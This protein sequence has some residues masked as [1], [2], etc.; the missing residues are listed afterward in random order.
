MCVCVRTCVCACMCVC[1][2]VCICVFVCVH[3]CV[4]VRVHVCVCM[5]VRV[6]VCAC[7]YVHETYNNTLPS[8]ESEA[9]LNFTFNGFKGQVITRSKFS[10]RKKSNPV[11]IND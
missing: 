5:C 10:F 6:H 3:V 1:M 11:R 2:C 8:A 9:G 4:H 7:V